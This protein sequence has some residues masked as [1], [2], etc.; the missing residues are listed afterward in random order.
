MVDS[1]QAWHLH[2]LGSPRQLRLC[3][4][5][6]PLLPSAGTVTL[7]HG[8]KPQLSSMANSSP[9]VSFTVEAIHYWLLLAPQR[10]KPQ[11][12]SVTPFRMQNH[13]HVGD[14]THHLPSSA[15]GLS[16][17]LGP[18]AQQFLKLALKEFFTKDG[19]G[20]LQLFFFLLQLT[21]INCPSKGFT[22]K[23][24][25]PK[26]HLNHL[27]EP[28]LPCEASQVVPPPSLSLY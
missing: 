8:F 18:S 7:P 10:A 6:E 21:C 13:D 25:K 20:F 27:T 11:L 4:P 23:D 17:S 3:L 16:C 9:V 1:P 19:A 12:F 5:Q 15:G 28:L 26:Y 22:S 2:I 14:S 24:S